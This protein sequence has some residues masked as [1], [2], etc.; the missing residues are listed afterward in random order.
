LLEFRLARHDVAYGAAAVT[1][2]GPMKEVLRTNDHI[3]LNYAMVLLEEAG[4]H[5]F[6]ADRFMSSA[7]GNI[8]AFQRRI[9]VPDE[10]EAKAKRALEALDKVEPLPDDYPVGEPD[11]EGM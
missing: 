4:C 8:S 11:G 3:Q 7:E 5:P 9:M 10:F 2:F 1:G 6:L